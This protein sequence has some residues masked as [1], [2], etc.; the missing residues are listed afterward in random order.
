MDRRNT[1]IGS[2][3]CAYGKIKVEKTSRKRHG[4]SRS[5]SKVSTEPI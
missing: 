1:P 2:F 4:G 3:L 5:C